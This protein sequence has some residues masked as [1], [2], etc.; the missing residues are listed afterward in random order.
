[1]I[2]SL[3][4]LLFAE[5]ADS[6][7]SVPEVDEFHLATC[8]ILVEIA[9][10]DDEFT[11]E[12]RNHIV[13]TMK[14]RFNMSEADAHRLIEAATQARVNSKDLWHFTNII[15]QSCTT[16]EKQK[17]ID[18]VWRVVFAD[19][20]MDGHENYLAHQMAKLFNLTHGQLIDSKVRILD[21][22]RNP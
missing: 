2:Q 5:T 9:L 11:D 1:M 6:P 14:S 18:E 17:L 13:S 4:S 7:D 15:N 3:K 10:A 16:D 19:G 21:Q 8:V 12:E 20:S 22:L